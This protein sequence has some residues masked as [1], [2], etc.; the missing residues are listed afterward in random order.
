[1][2]LILPKPLST[3]HGKP[4]RIS[5]HKTFFLKAT[6]LTVRLAFLPRK[7]FYVGYVALSLVFNFGKKQATACDVILKSI[8]SGESHCQTI[9]FRELSDRCC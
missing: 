5:R 1:M 6:F 9:S 4:G 8:K 7:P 2:D 3:F